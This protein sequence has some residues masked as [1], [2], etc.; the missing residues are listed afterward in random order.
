MAKPI[1]TQALAAH[2]TE[3][4]QHSEEPTLAPL[5]VANCLIL[6]LSAGS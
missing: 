3:M 6:L 4:S 1:K 2:Y 5:S